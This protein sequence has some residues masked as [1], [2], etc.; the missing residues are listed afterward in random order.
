MGIDDRHGSTRRTARIGRM[1]DFLFRLGTARWRSSQKKVC[2]AREESACGSPDTRGAV[3]G[4]RNARV[5]SRFRLNFATQ[6]A[7]RALHGA[8]IG[9]PPMRAWK[10]LSGFFRRAGILIKA[11]AWAT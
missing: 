8:G 5:S 3:H 10:R 1:E 7:A 11:T 9:R 4:H 2:G 6:F